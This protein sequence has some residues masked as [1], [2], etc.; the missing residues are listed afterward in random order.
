[1]LEEHFSVTKDKIDII[2]SRRI[3]ERINQMTDKIEMISKNLRN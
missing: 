3:I 2:K 1:M